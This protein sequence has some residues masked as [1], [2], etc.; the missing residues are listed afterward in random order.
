M[1][2]QLQPQEEQEQRIA[3]IPSNHELIAAL[4][5]RLNFSLAV[6]TYNN[7]R[8]FIFHPNNLDKKDLRPAHARYVEC[9][10]D[11]FGAR[12]TGLAVSPDLQEIALAVKNQI[13]FLDA[14][15]GLQNIHGSFPVPHDVVY[16]PRSTHYTGDIAAHD[17]AWVEGKLRIAS[18]RFS[19]VVRLPKKAHFEIAWRPKFVTG[20]PLADDRCHLNGISQDGRYVSMFGVSDKT[21][22]WRAEKLTGGVVIDTH[23]DKTVIGGLCM[24]HSPRVY[25][26][27]VYVLSSGRGE[28]VSADGVEVSLPGYLRG[29]AFHGHYAFIGSGICR[30][31]NYVDKLPILERS[32]LASGVWIHN[33][34]THQ[35]EAVI[36]FEGVAEVYDVQV[37]PG[38]LLPGIYSQLNPMSEGIFVS[39]Q[40]H[41]VEFADSRARQLLPHQPLPLAKGLAGEAPTMVMSK[42]P[43]QQNK[44]A[45][46]GKTH[47][48]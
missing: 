12:C 35:T 3:F 30:E 13:V 45:P 24:P 2:Q 21:D 46:N 38:V 14:Q 9:T 1:H 6:T 28:L 39:E 47:L 25:D 29:L 23:T 7:G 42:G 33:M 43:Y 31:K 8:V 18:S 37:L 4:M 16:T 32:P 48:R 22:G 40:L 27:K 10:T 5:L 11:A 36:Q 20:T 26:G 34:L 44:V 15:S 19:S 41:P 17:M